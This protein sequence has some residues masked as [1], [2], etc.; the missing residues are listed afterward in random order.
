MIT[1]GGA[2]WGVHIVN[3][4]A[5]ADPDAIAVFNALE[6]YTPALSP[7]SASYPS[8]LQGSQER[9]LKQSSANW[10]VR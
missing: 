3:S 7:A 10:S 9:G 8:Q 6:W 1:G 5:R 2:A 4:R